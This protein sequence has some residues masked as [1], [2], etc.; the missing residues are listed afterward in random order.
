[1]KILNVS[2]YYK[3]N[4]KK[5]FLF[6]LHNYTFLFKSEN[7]INKN[8]IPQENPTRTHTFKVFICT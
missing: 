5:C 1:M 6:F 3:A 7:I 4:Q 8:K 2:L